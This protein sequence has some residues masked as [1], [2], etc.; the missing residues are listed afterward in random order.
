MPL[1]ALIRNLAKMTD[2]GLLAPHSDATAR[3]GRSGW[4]M[5]ALCARRVSTRIACWRR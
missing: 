2:V 4:A 5:R 1:T 3:R